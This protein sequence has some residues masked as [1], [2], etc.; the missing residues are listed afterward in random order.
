MR[1]HMKKGKT[2]KM[3][4]GANA[5]GERD[6]YCGAEHAKMFHQL[7]TN[8]VLGWKKRSPCTRR[9]IPQA[10]KVSAQSDHRTSFV[11]SS[12]VASFSSARS[13]SIASMLTL[14]SAS[15]ASVACDS[16]TSEA[17]VSASETSTPSFDDVS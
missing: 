2:E 5:S 7:Q 11:A 3:P 14:F 4:R 13:A 17:S 16:T 15:S 8:R 6:Y 1:L 9:T 10:R 12:G